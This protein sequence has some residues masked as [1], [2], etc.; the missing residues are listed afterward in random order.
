MHPDDHLHNFKKLFG[1]D[2]ERS[3]RKFSEQM[4]S[5]VEVFEHDGTLHFNLD[6][7]PFGRVEGEVSV[8]LAHCFLMVWAGHIWDRARRGGSFADS[9]F[10]KSNLKVPLQISHTE[11]G[12]IEM[13]EEFGRD[14]VIQMVS[15]FL[16]RLK[17]L[18][19]RTLC[20]AL[21]SMVLDMEENEL[22]QVKGRR[23]P[24]VEEQEKQAIRIWRD[25]MSAQKVVR[26][27]QWTTI[28]RRRALELYDDTLRLFKEL[29]RTYFGCKAKAI[30]RKNPGLKT[31]SQVTAEY[32]HLA[33]LLNK[34]PGRNPKELALVHVGKVFGSHG[35][36][37]TYRQI[38]VAMA[39]RRE[40]AE[41]SSGSCSAIV[42]RVVDD[43]MKE[44]AHKRRRH[45]VPHKPQTS[46]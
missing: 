39:E 24:I 23:G 29:K 2:K 18:P 41:V 14:A 38:K 8:E 35:S 6:M 43:L 37:Y 1:D 17:T 45:N 40:A 10:S 44:M 21:V 46:H 25:E 4:D 36:T 9:P 3:F 26:T 32:P 27:R 33:P 7:E 30:L 19:R 5:Q 20:D 42:G 15:Q 34:L 22:L 13:L 31:W 12:L 11:S 16:Y 28:K